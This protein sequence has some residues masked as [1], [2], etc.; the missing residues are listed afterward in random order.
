MNSHVTLRKN[1]R[2]V[3]ENKTYASATKYSK[4]IVVINRSHLKRIKRNL[5]KNYFDNYKSFMKSF[6]GAEKEHMKH[7]VIPSSKE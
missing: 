1:Q 4:E 6:G 7:Y 3:A 5:F 2:V